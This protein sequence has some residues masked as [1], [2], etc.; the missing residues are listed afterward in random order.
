MRTAVASHRAFTARIELFL[1]ARIEL[2][3]YPCGTMCNCNAETMPRSLRQYCELH[4]GLSV[5]VFLW[6]SYRQWCDTELPQCLC[7]CE[8]RVVQ[9][10]KLQC[11]RIITR[12]WLCSFCHYSNAWWMLMLQLV[13]KIPH[14][15]SESVQKIKA[16]H[17]CCRST[18]LS[19]CWDTTM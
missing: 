7:V 2:G 3:F 19:E 6:R 11:G 10:N 16:R 8:F 18:V 15:P 14:K 17:Y 9:T 4:V 1:S 13:L 12:Y 5:L